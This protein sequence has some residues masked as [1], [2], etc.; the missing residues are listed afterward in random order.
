[1]T[2]ALH[3]VGPRNKYCKRK[4]AIPWG[5][6][7]KLEEGRFRLG[8]DIRKKIFAVRMVRC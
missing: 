6:G 4:L 5:N 7:F 3:T 8:I 1:M 2:T